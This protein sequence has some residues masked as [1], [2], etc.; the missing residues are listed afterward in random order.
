MDKNLFYRHMLENHQINVH[1]NFEKYAIVVPKGYY[2]PL[3]CCIPSCNFS[4]FSVVEL[5]V[6]HQIAHT[7]DPVVEQLTRDFNNL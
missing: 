2:W 1:S 4:S 7:S 6:H 5:N 3:K